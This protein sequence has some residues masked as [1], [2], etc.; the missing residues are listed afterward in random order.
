[1]SGKESVEAFI[2]SYSV[3][4]ILCGMGVVIELREFEPAQEFHNARVIVGGVI[5]WTFTDYIRVVVKG[6]IL[7]YYR[8]Y[9]FAFGV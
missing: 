1:M 3:K 8:N 7:K 2:Y 5:G 4:L 6:N 9:C